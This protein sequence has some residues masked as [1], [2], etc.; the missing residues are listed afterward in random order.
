MLI[1]PRPGSHKV[2]Q[3]WAY[4]ERLRHAAISNYNVFDLLA[5]CDKPGV[6]VYVDPPYVGAEHRYKVAKRV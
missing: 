3:L 5:K 6:L 1:R 2:A 4:A